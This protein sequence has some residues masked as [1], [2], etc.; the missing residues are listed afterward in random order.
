MLIFEK[1]PL[2]WTSIVMQIKQTQR[3]KSKP[4]LTGPWLWV[5]LGRLSW[6]WLT[7]L[8]SQMESIQPKSKL[9]ILGTET[10]EFQNEKWSMGTL[11][12]MG[13]MWN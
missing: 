12:L 7:Y 6:I 5:V 3:D 8:V 13:A 10:I 9:F 1:S 2:V 11:N 4:K